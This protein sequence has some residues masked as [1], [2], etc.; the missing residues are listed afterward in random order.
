MSN[1]SSLIMD[2]RVNKL[3]PKPLNA[4]VGIGLFR[5]TASGSGVEDRSVSLINNT[6]LTIERPISALVVRTDKPISVTLVSEDGGTSVLMCNDLLVITQAMRSVE[7][8]YADN[9]AAPN[10]SSTVSIIFT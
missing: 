6:P 3:L 7:L 2:L 1:T 5:V 4:S 9:S 10:A 8:E